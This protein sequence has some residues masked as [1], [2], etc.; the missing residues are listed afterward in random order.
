VDHPRMI[1]LRCQYANFPSG[2]KLTHYPHFAFSP[3]VAF[4]E[5]ESIKDVQATSALDSFVSEVETTVEHIET[6]ARRLYPG[7]FQ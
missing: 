3:F 1:H 2:R 7:A 6:E 5:I 4:G